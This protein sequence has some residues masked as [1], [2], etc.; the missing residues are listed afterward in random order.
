MVAV[1]HFLVWTGHQP[2]AWVASVAVDGFFLLSGYVLSLGYR[3]PIWRFWLARAARLWP[4]FAICLLAGYA[5][6]SSVPPIGA[7]FWLPGPWFAHL[8]Q[9][10]KP[11]WTLFIEAWLSAALP[12]LALLARRSP[13]AVWLLAAVSAGAFH[14]Q[15]DQLFVY[16]CLFCCG[17]AGSRYPLVFPAFPRSLHWTNWIG[18]RAYSIYLT[19]WL[20]F[21]LASQLAGVEGVILA[22]P[23]EFV[24]ISVAYRW[25]ERPS[26]RLSVRIRRGRALV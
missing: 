25:I 10:D 21:E 9:T 23:V 11:V 2:W 17:V 20:V 3:G 15:Q 22:V 26:I 14:V 1:S 7:L 12:F 19:N 24:V 13:I 5:L 6:H 8:D 18:E 16:A 4:L